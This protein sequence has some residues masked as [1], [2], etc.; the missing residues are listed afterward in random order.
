MNVP[1]GWYAAAY[2]FV[3]VATGQD[4][5]LNEVPVV[6]VALAVEGTGTGSKKKAA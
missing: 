4:T 5:R 1:P 6:Q 3:N 2:R